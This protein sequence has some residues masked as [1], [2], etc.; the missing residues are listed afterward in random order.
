MNQAVKKTET[1]T[2]EDL[3][4]II[5]EQTKEIAD[6][7]EFRYRSILAEDTLKKINNLSN[8]HIVGIHGMTNKRVGRNGA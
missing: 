2:V 4:K 5:S 7:K 3:K 8:F 1:K 6:L